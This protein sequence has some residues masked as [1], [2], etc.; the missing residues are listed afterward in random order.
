MVSAQDSLWASSYQRQDH[1]CDLPRTLS[2]PLDLQGVRPLTGK[3][4]SSPSCAPSLLPGPP[5]TA[6]PARVC[7]LGY[8]EE[9]AG[10]PMVPIGA[11]PRCTTV[12]VRAQDRTAALN[13]RLDRAQP[14]S[15]AAGTRAAAGHRARPACHPH[16]SGPTQRPPSTRQHPQ[17]LNYTPGHLTLVMSF[18]FSSMSCRKV[19]EK[20]RSPS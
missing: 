2:C 4:G 19:G 9:G 15:S 12:W 7:V 14:H 6:E 1:S 8:G 17:G 16:C 5:S 20:Q 3:A 18:P 10:N 13:A 11:L